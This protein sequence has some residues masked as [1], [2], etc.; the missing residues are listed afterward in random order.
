MSVG[1]PKT[2]ASPFFRLT[3]GRIVCLYGFLGIAWILF[4]DMAVAWFIHD[5][6]QYE[7]AGIVKGIFFVITTAVAMYFLIR[8]FAR[9][10][11]TS[12]QTMRHAEQQIEQL[13]HY[14]LETGLPNGHLLLDRLGQ[15][16]AYC[17]RKK[18]GTC[19][20]YVSLTG[21]KS[22]VDAYGHFGGHDVLK[23]IGDRLVAALRQYDTVS[24]IHRD[25]FVIVLGEGTS[26]ADVAVVLNKLLKVF[27]EPFAHQH[28][29]LIIPAC[30]GIACF[31]ADGLTGDLLI[32][33]AHLAVNQA[34]KK[35]VPYQYFSEEFNQKATDRQ[36]IET[37]LLKALDNGDF[38][39]HYQPRYDLRT[40]TVIGMEALVRWQHPEHGLIPPAKFIPVAEDNGLIVRL[41]AYVLY[42]ACRQ[43]REWQEA[44]LLKLRVAVNIS[45]RQLADNDFV[46]FVIQTL[47]Q[48]GLAPRYLE[49]ELTESV[50]MGN[51]EDTI[52]KLLRLKEHG[53]SISVDDFGT[54]YSSLSYLKHLPIDTIKIDRSFV[55][56]IPTAPDNTAIVE[57]IIAMAGAL[58]LNVV[59]EGV[60]SLEQLS[61]LQQ[62]SCPEAQ[63]YFFSRP[64]SSH[65]FEYQ[66][67]SGN[68]TL[69]TAGGCRLEF[70]PDRSSFRGTW[71]Y[72]GV[73]EWQLDWTGIRVEAQSEA[74]APLYLTNYGTVLL[75]EGGAAMDGS[76]Q[77]DR[78]VAGVMHGG[79]FTGT[80]RHNAGQ[81]FPHP[82]Q[83]VKPSLVTTPDML[84]AAPRR[85]AAVQPELL[86]RTETIGDISCKPPTIRPG[87]TILV[88][89][90]RFQADRELTVLPVVELGK[91]VGIINRSSF[92]E[93]HVI[94]RHGFGLH[95]NYAKK[96][97]DLML[98][99]ELTVDRSATIEE[100]ATL[101][102][103][104]RHVLTRIDNICVTNGDEYFGIVNVNRLVDAITSINLALAKGANPLTGL[105]GNESIQREIHQRLARKMPFDIAYIDID[106]FKPFN[107]NYSFQKGD[108]VIK[109][110]GDMAMG[111]LGE[112]GSRSFLGH[113][114]GDDF[115]VITEP[116]LSE[117]VANDII[118]S[119]EA[120]L[121]EFHGEED[122]AIGSYRST[123]RKGEQ[124][125]FALLSLSIGIVNTRVTPVSSYAQLAS[126]S[127]EV[128]KAAKKISGSSVVMNRRGA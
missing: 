68:K 37:G 75:L 82:F 81:G 88:A 58:D 1:F 56:D 34:R 59:A 22:I 51:Q 2:L 101:I 97:R 49:L 109:S 61:F 89:L 25:E 122:F 113:I 33:N 63:G 11:T 118:V 43:N 99:V 5:I 92:L 87:D 67:R 83:M 21:Y 38:M 60:E 102:Q 23:S 52:C 124:E 6:H 14:D 121:A 107:D 32:K 96:I 86:P 114:G 120:N 19:V 44:G 48:T 128:K 57:A 47:E 8:H 84:P 90:N 66:L 20:I 55:R 95:I 64:V 98:P 4:S 62:R 42:E 78:S 13:S 17:S 72:H 50:L 108:T 29:E 91:V 10:L 36:S 12:Q 27:A 71:H 41:G 45:A 103:A 123:N 76:C 70:S 65:H 30:F 28:Q 105:P 104:S 53:V 3:P 100:A 111:V 15:T 31:P 115:I 46:P 79:H 126:L 85:D 35:G 18:I 39:L 9:Q 112:A 73:P 119:F 94:G 26:E 54:G 93:E 69:E 74:P 110:L 116:H 117:K 7:R 77:G 24:R 16:I 40:T 80:W 127:T 106:N 125:T